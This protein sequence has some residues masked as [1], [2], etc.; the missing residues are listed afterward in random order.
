M[1]VCQCYSSAVA[2]SGSL[3]HCWLNGFDTNSSSHMRERA[4]SPEQLPQPPIRRIQTNGTREPGRRARGGR[5][6]NRDT[7][8]L[9]VHIRHAAVLLFLFR[10]IHRLLFLA[11]SVAQLSVI[12]HSAERLFSTLINLLMIFSVIELNNCL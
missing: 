1:F 5:W 9:S 7:V 3:P 8:S 2:H 4:V 6:S 10:L 11:F 12:H